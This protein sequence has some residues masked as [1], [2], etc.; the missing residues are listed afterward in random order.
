LVVNPFFNSM[1][2]KKIFYPAVSLLL[3]VTSAFMIKAAVSWK[4]VDEK[5]SIKFSTEEAEG[6]IKGLKGTIKFDEAD[7]EGS[8]FNVTADVNTINT[9]NGMKNKH[10][11]G[12]EWLDATTYP[13]IKFVSS[14]FS[15]TSSGYDVKGKLTLKGVTKDVTIPFTFASKGK[16]GTFK[17]GF[18]L[19]RKDYNITNEGVGD[20]L[21]IELVVPVKQ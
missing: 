11:K 16:T 2:M 1:H 21:K 13:T 19:E 20:V 14:S 7:L 10:A 18:K 4:I 17:G 9:G 15:K 3:V 5:Y 8:L 12:K 6:I